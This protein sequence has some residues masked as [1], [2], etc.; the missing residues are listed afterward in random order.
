MV[1]AVADVGAV[2]SSDVAVGGSDIED[3]VAGSTSIGGCS[4][5]G[6]LNTIFGGFFKASMHFWISASQCNGLM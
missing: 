1:G 5:S 6:T 2:G 3:D 4:G